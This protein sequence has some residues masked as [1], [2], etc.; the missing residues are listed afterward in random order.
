MMQLHKGRLSVEGSAQKVSSPGYFSF[1]NERVGHFMSDHKLL[2][3]LHPWPK[4]IRSY[5]HSQ[6]RQKDESTKPRQ[7]VRRRHGII[8]ANYL[9]N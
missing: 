4:C 5:S 2:H 7:M 1:D 3:F 8:Q 9:Y 6:Y